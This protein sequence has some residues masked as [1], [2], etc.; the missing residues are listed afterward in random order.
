M[1][2]W[3]SSVS[4]LHDV[5]GVFVWAHVLFARIVVEPNGFTITLKI[6]V[7]YRCTCTRKTEREDQTLDV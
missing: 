7:G 5:L 2:L 3:L 1:D 6:M 4:A